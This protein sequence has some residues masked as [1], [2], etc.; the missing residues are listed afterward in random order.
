MVAK[1]VSSRKQKGYGFQKKVAEQIRNTFGLEERD[2]VSTPS[3]VKGEDL[4]LSNKA[5]ECF[6]FAV[7]AKRQEKLNIWEALKQ[8]EVNATIMKVKHQT[9]FAPL[10]VF[11]R[12]RSKTY[13]CLE[14][15]DFLDIVKGCEWLKEGEKE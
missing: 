11:K 3:S 2:I 15:N 8:S 13:V 4:L 5:I 10:L 1:S 9:Y 14:F 12:N 7:E 6:P